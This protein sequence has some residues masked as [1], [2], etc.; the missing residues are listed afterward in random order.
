MALSKLLSFWL[1]MMCIGTSL[2]AQNILYIGGNAELDPRK[3]DQDLVDSLNSWGYQATYMAAGTYKSAPANV[4]NGYDGIWI[5]ESVGS[6]DVARFSTDDFPLDII[7]M[8]PAPLAGAWGMG[9]GIEATEGAIGDY[10]LR[11][12]NTDHY[13]T[14]NYTLG[15][16]LTVC[17]NPEYDHTGILFDNEGVVSD[18]LASVTNTAKRGGGSISPGG[19]EVGTI[20]SSMDRPIR[21]CLFCLTSPNYDNKTTASNSQAVNYAT[22]AFYAF[23]ERCA[24]WT[25]RKADLA[26]N[27]SSHVS[28]PKGRELKI[29][30]D[31]NATR[32][33]VG[34]HSPGN[35]TVRAYLTDLNG[36]KVASL[37]EGRTVAGN[38]FF[39]I[40]PNSF[41][42]GLYFVQLE[43]PEALL[44]SK[45]ILSQN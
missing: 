32:I 24:D 19:F 6:T 13:I 16:E 30:R 5:N 37:F 7:L 29:I 14:E 17:T 10:I 23:L 11:I 2:S 42:E 4:Y 28:S 41:S 18:I 20:D 15:E 44:H 27:L 45:I 33:I 8:E 1:V 3:M 40:N 26:T 36:Q 9:M 25:Y 12:D 38:N 39:Q 34:Y 22:E 43:T 21:M 35:E 31:F